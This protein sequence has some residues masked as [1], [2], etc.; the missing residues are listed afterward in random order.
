[1]YLEAFSTLKKFKVSDKDSEI[2][3]N[4]VGDGFVAHYYGDEDPSKNPGLDKSRLGLWGRV[5][6]MVQQYVLDGL[7]AD[8]PPNDNDV[9]LDLR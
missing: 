5:V 1:V 2:I 7:W 6:L 3:A 9:T 8:L 4:A